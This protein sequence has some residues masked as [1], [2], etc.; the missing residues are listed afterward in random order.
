MP[1]GEIQTT[2]VPHSQKPLVSREYPTEAELEQAVLRSAA[3]QKQWSKVPL[4][5]RIAIGYKFI[6][7][8]GYQIR[9]LRSCR[10]DQMVVG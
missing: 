3:A 6:V 10:V 9:M 8:I 7:S 1:S 4:K 5:Q 2:I